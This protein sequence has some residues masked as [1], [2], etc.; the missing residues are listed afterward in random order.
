MKFYWQQQL[1]A[2]TFLIKKAKDEKGL[3]LYVFLF[4]RKHE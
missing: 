3:V 1:H 2:S 4:S